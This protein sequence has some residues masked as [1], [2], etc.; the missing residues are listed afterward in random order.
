M[1]TTTLI[2]LVVVVAVVLVALYLFRRAPAAEPGLS[3]FVFSPSPEFGVTP[4]VKRE[5][6]IVAPDQL[7]AGKTRKLNVTALP[8]PPE[9][10]Q[11]PPKEKG[12]DR[13]L[14]S[15]INPR[16][17]YSDTGE[18]ATNFDPPLTFT[19]TYSAEDLAVAP[20]TDGRPQISIVTFYQDGD[21][22]RWERLVT[23]IDAKAMTCSAQVRTLTPSDPA[24]MGIP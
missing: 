13:L 23:D 18:T 10:S 22:T 11:T 16:V 21:F 1:D 4:L 9:P 15:V 2:V 3:R 7:S 20:Q 14:T 8:L 6:T 12:I 17:Q 5:V 24:G 19:F